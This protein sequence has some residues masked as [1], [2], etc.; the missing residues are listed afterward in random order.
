MELK[1]LP[2]MCSVRLYSQGFVFPHSLFPSPKTTR[3][4]HPGD[5]HISELVGM[6]WQLSAV[7]M[8]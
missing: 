4:I 6:A 3:R 7:C 1:F 5:G 8:R 2:W